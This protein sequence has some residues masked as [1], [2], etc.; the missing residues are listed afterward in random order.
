MEIIQNFCTICFQNDGSNL[1]NFSCNHTICYDCFFFSIIGDESLL[2]K[3]GTKKIC[4]LCSKGI[5]EIPINELN[6]YLTQ[7]FKK[8]IICPNKLDAKKCSYCD[9]INAINPRSTILNQVNQNQ[10]LHFCEECKLVF[11]NKCIEKNH[12]FHKKITLN[13]ISSEYSK[14]GKNNLKEWVKVQINSF[15]IFEKNFLNNINEEISYFSQD[16]EKKVDELIFFL[17]ALKTKN[18]EFFS[19][20][21]QNNKKKSNLIRISLKVIEKYIEEC[22]N[23]MNDTKKYLILKNFQINNQILIQSPADLASIKAK[24]SSNLMKANFFSFNKNKLDKIQEISNNLKSSL[25]FMNP[26]HFLEKERELLEKGSFWPLY[27]KSGESCSF[28][29]N[30]M[31]YI[32]WAGIDD[33]CAN[34]PLVIYNLNQRKRETVLNADSNLAI[35]NVSTYPKG[36]L[37]LGEKTDFKWLYTSSRNGV[38]RIYNISNQTPSQNFQ[39]IHTIDTKNGEICQ[40]VI[41]EDKFSEI[42]TQKSIFAIISFECFLLRRY[43][44]SKGNWDKFIEIKNP[45]QLLCRTINFYHDFS[46]GKTRF[47]FGFSKSFVVMYGLGNCYDSKV[48]FP[49]SSNV[50][51]IQFLSNRT[52]N[53]N[54]ENSM[55]YIVYSE[56]SPTITLGDLKSGAILR[57]ISIANINKISDILISDKFILLSC[58]NSN[59]NE[60]NNQSSYIK[61][62][63]SEDFSVVYSKEVP[64]RP[65][66]LLKTIVLEN[67][68]ENITN[69]KDVFLI[70]QNCSKKDNS[71]VLYS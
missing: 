66:N 46:L 22:D 13:E 53:K 24:D 35:T 36:N 20:E 69:S 18:Q 65:F 21:F 61:I 68:N 19:N 5:I 67:K 10:I 52:I 15:N 60:P 49:T 3:P 7:F 27:Y 14:I 25:D 4:S 42:S 6:I 29:L 37:E 51:S 1:L 59:E 45:C 44:F 55:N 63:D 43:Q 64:Y 56:I 71:V 11:C 26:A 54:N 47:F 41:F 23:L 9:N 39:E 57:Q 70:F 34:C 48:R 8:D 40:T 2:S 62:V 33:S 38:V 17:Q 30:E 50:T 12:K 32:A 16:F 58:L 31:T 28:L